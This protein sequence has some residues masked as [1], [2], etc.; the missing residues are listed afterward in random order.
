MVSATKEPQ[1]AQSRR[2]PFGPKK[3]QFST[4][5]SQLL[6]IGHISMFAA[7]REP[8]WGSRNAHAAVAAVKDRVRIKFPRVVGYLPD[9]QDAA[10]Q[11]VLQ[12]A[13][14]LSAERAAR[15]AAGNRFVGALPS[16]SE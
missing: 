5:S 1:G 9:L 3:N 11:N 16:L 6:H 12:Q 2:P 14:A 10:V 13:E 15:V 7:I 8:R 4:G